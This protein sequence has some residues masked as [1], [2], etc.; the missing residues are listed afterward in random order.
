MFDR[1]AK[2]KYHVKLKKCKL[3]CKKVESLGHTV[4]VAGVGVA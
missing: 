2:F 4:S 1:L 3:F